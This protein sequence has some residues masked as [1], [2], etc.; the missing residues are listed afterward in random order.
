MVK[1]QSS[2]FSDINNRYSS[3]ELINDSF[4]DYNIENHINE[5]KYNDALVASLDKAVLV[6]KYKISIGCGSGNNIEP[7]DVFGDNKFIHIKRNNGSS[8]LSHLFNQALVSSQVILDTSSRNQFRDKLKNAG[9]FD[10]IP[11]HFPS[12]NYEIVIAIINKFND[13]FLIFH[14][15]VKCLYVMLPQICR[16]MDIK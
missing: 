16:I 9:E 5:E 4:I 8:N 12:S 3:I 10:I 13:G 11:E 2:F 6:H 7:C 15:L 1:Y 14:F